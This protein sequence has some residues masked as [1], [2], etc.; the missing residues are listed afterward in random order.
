[1]ARR[2]IKKQLG[3]SD[4]PVASFSDL[5]FLLII[6]FILTTTFQKATGFL[7][8]MP[9]GAKG[10]TQEKT[11]TVSLHDNNINLNDQ[12]VTMPELRARLREMKL[13][14]KEGD[15][16]MVL[17][18]ATGNV[19]YQDYF[20]TMAVISSAGGVIVIESEDDG[21]KQ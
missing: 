11:P 6:F 1:M 12:N 18:R 15:A 5:A 16:K 3:E 9:A 10:E 7:T 2:F 14:E 13:D 17:L 21:K 20:E 19:V 4:I 8:E